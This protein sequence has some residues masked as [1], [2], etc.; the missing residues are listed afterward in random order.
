MWILIKVV[1]YP[2]IV[3]GLVFFVATCSYWLSFGKWLE[4]SQEE[5]LPLYV[6]LWL[7]SVLCWVLYLS[8]T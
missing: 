7:F 6:L 1:I 2:A 4:M 8:K 3:T 5:F